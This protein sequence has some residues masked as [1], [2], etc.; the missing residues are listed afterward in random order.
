VV[1]QRPAT[2]ENASRDI[3]KDFA[4][5]SIKAFPSRG[6]NAYLRGSMAS[7]QHG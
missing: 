3:G 2:I 7:W 6:S 4:H 5:N 1:K